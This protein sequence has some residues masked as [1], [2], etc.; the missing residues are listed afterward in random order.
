MSILSNKLL[1]SMTTGCFHSVAVR[2]V[3]MLEVALIDFIRWF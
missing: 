1:L 3:L 2:S